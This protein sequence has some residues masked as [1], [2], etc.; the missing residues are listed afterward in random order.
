M[1]Q[2]RL[3]SKF[4]CIGLVRAGKMFIFCLR[5]LPTLNSKRSRTERFTITFKKHLGLTNFILNNAL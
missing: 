2:S 4:Q 3:R 1:W 5:F